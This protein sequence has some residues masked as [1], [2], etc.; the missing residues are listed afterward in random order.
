MLGRAERTR[1]GDILVANK[2][3]NIDRTDGTNRIVNGYRLQHGMKANCDTLTG[4][5]E[6]LC[7]TFSVERFEVRSFESHTKF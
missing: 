2:I 7:G 1:R 5:F 4:P 6:V 3:V